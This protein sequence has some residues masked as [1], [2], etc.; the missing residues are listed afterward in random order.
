MFA[1]LAVVLTLSASAL[2]NVFVTAPVASTTWNGGQKQ[3]VSW[4]DNGNAPD[5]KAFGAAMISIYVGNA[6]QQTRLQ[7]ISPSTDV[8]T[9]SSVDFTVDATIG[10]NSD[11][12]FVRFESIG[13]KDPAA[14]QFPALAFSAKF[15]M[16]GMTGTFNSTVQA[17]I[18]G[19]STA[20]IGG[21]TP[22]AGASTAP[23]ASG[24]A[25]PSKAASTTATP[26]KTSSSSTAKPS[27]G[28][29]KVEH[30]GYIAVAAAA[31]AL[32]VAL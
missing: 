7:T 10:P 17:Q 22:P 27:S 12:Y 23:A 28:A 8:S 19:Q 18:D 16:A 4:Q 32:A 9:S 2:C 31:A 15:K 21:S 30:A 25:A 13:L 20:P 5:L 1:Q 24:S 29:T 14:P 11:D 26:A 3:T 6:Q